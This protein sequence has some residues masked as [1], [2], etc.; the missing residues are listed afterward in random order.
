[1]K[2]PLETQHQMVY[3]SEVYA[4]IQ[5]ANHKHNERI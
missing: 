2:F 5:A 1:M 4:Q 3:N